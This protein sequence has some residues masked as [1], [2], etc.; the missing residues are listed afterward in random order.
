MAAFT[1]I[2]SSHPNREAI[3]WALADGI[4]SGYGDGSFRPDAEINRA[5][6]TKIV[7]GSNFTPAAASI[8]DPGNIYHYKDAGHSEWFSPYLCLASQHNIIKGYTDGT[9]RPGNPINFVEAA[10]IIAI[11]SQFQDGIQKADHL[12]FSPRAGQEWFEPYVEYLSERSAIPETINENSHFVTRG[13]MVEILYLLA[14][15][16]SLGSIEELSEEELFITK[17]IGSMAYKGARD[18]SLCGGI[19]KLESLACS[20]QIAAY[21]PPKVFDDGLDVTISVHTG[22]SKSAEKTITEG[23][24][25]EDIMPILVNGNK[26]Y[27]VHTYFGSYYYWLHGNKEIEVGVP[28]ICVEELLS[29]IE[30]SGE[31]DGEEISDED[32]DIMKSM[33]SALDDLAAAYIRKYP[34][35]LR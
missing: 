13:E 22:L 10:K 30:Q 32:L 35:D 4:I 7:I 18:A 9:F 11:I 21:D 29:A 14:I 25:K 16:D 31:Y 6:F 20:S 26:V 5:E 24:S 15:H 27:K 28:M 17:D 33:C 2:P 3:L 12:E 8:C 1:D 23:F 19:V 34:S